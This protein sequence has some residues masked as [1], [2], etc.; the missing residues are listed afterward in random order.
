MSIW[1]SNS[2]LR[3]IPKRAESRCLHKNR[4]RSV[5]NSKK[6]ETTQIS[7]HRWMDKQSGIYP[8]NGISFS[9]N[10]EGGPDRQEWT[11]KLFSVK[12]ARHGRS[13]LICFHLDEMFRNRQIL[14]SFTSFVMLHRCYTFYRLKVCG[15]LHWGS[16]S[17]PFFPT[18]FAHFG[19]LSHILVSLTTFQTFS[20]LLYFLW[21]SVIFN[22]T[23]VTVWRPYRPH[24]Y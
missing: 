1:L 21:W 15:T 12:E 18:A 14:F 24:S 20:W 23:I 19:S 22:V 3:C 4:Y 6:V 10:K 9:H 5:H 8:C 13:H 17:A 2:A 7:V 11:L 16:H